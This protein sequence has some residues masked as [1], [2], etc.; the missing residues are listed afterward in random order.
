MKPYLLL[1]ICIF[2]GGGVIGCAHRE[3]ITIVVPELREETRQASWAGCKILTRYWRGKQKIYDEHAVGYKGQI[4]RSYFANGQCVMAESDEDGDGFFETITLFPDS[5]Q[6]M[7]V[8]RRQ[9]DG[10]VK[11]LESKE[12]QELKEKIGRAVKEFRK[13]EK[14]N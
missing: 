4:V 5:L 10:S 12:L 11:P 6:D 13:A 2:A 9:T 8:F 7:D 14:S 1:I 3:G